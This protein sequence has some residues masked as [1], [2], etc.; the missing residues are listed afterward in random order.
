MAAGAC[1][2]GVGVVK[3]RFAVA[4]CGVAAVAL[5]IGADMA[6]RL[7]GGDATVVAA[8]AAAGRDGQ[9]SRDVAALAG[10]TGVRAGERKAGLHVIERDWIGGMGGARRNQRQ[11]DQQKQCQRDAN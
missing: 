8:R 6:D 3:L 2:L 10:H 5:S 1:A 9:H 7:A 11:D 4:G